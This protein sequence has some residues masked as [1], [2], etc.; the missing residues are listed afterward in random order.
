MWRLRGWCTAV[1]IPWVKSFTLPLTGFVLH[2]PEFISLNVPC[3]QPTTLLPFTLT[4]LCL[5]KRFGALFVYI[6]PRKP[7]RETCYCFKEHILTCC[8]HKILGR[9]LGWHTMYMR[10]SLIITIE[11][12]WSFQAAFNVSRKLLLSE[13]TTSLRIFK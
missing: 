3:E 9:H 5:L 11:V 6:Y 4:K 1:V 10:I 7:Y 13:T 8:C 2:C 12:W